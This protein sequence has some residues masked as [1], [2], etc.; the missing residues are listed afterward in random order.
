M[1]RFHLI[2]VRSISTSNHFQVKAV[3]TMIGRHSM[4]QRKRG[5]SITILCSALETLADEGLLSLSREETSQGLESTIATSN[6]IKD[7]ICDDLAHTS[8]L[9]LRK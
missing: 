4:H 9:R 6:K 5:C 3:P 2:S 8:L 7:K 1:Y